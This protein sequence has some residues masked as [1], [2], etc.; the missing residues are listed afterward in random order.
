MDSL[1]VMPHILPNAMSQIWATASTLT[2]A[3]SAN[4]D[5]Y[6]KRVIPAPTN[7]RAVIRALS[8]PR[9]RDA[10]D[11]LNKLP[12]FELSVANFAHWMTFGG[13]TVLLEFL[14][15]DLSLIE[16]NRSGLRF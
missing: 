8:H 5:D 6:V 10:I 2:S 14:S 11:K 1:N 3:A 4:R 13:S 15:L 16:S 9:L 7:F 12:F